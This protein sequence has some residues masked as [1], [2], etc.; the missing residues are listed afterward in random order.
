MRATVDLDNPAVSDVIEAWDLL[1]EHGDGIVHGRVS[2]SGSG[3]HL[4]VHGCD[5]DTAEALRYAAR[6]DSKRIGFDRKSH[7][8]PKQ[9]LFSSKGG[10]EA[11]EW[12]T[13]GAEVIEE[14]ER[15]APEWYQYRLLMIC[16]PVLAEVIET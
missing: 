2:S 3:V 13:D 7:L 5:P 12:S 16:Y 8:K 4:K 10:R 1:A 6:D 9:I 14:F 15:R 11:G